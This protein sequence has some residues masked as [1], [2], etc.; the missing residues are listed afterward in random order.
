MSFL[1]KLKKKAEELELDEKAKELQEAATTA[2]KQAREK[3]GDFTAENREKIDGYVDKAASTDRREDRRQVRRQGGQGQADG[4]QGRRQGRR[5]L[6]QRR[7]ISPT[8]L[9]LRP[10]GCCRAR[11]PGPAPPA[12]PGS[13]AADPASTDPSTFPVD[14]QAPPAPAPRDARRRPHQACRGADG[15]RNGCGIR[16]RGCVAWWK[17]AGWVRTTGPRRM[18]V[19]HQAVPHGGGC[20]P[21]SQRRR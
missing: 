21:G 4:R 18:H 9:L 5:G 17:L 6:N 14:P 13:P 15:G 2:A 10:A 7:R 19:S 8:I 11:L 20:R 1:D 12:M 3:A 16:T